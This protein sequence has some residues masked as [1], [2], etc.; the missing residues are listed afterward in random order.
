MSEPV[1]ISPP[2]ETKEFTEL[3]KRVD[4]DKPSK[5]DVKALRRWFEDDP[6]LALEATNMA[7]IVMTQIIQIAS[8]QKSVRMCLETGLEHLQNEMGYQEAPMLEKLLIE[9]ISMC[10]LRLQWTEYQFTENTTGSHALTAGR[11]WDSRVNAAQMRYLRAIEALA[12]VRKV[13]IA[14]QVNIAKQQINSLAALDN[15]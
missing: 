2:K 10:W 15:L 14:I 4:K 12:R 3:L 1:V 11:Y 9:S 7:N 6:S 13:N 5:E 8:K